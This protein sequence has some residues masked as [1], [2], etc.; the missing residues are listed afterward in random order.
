MNKPVVLAVIDGLGL[1]N[2]EQ[3]NAFAQA[4]TPV[5]DQLLSEY[6]NSVLGAASESVGLPQG[7]IGNSEVGH[8]NI[9]AGEVV[10]TGLSL[11]N[12]SIQQD[13]FKENK[14]LLES[15]EHAKKNNSTLHL[16][17]M[18]SP[19]GVHSLEDHL[20]E[21]IKLLKSKNV[22][23]VTIHAFTDGRDVKPR[24]V[25]S[26]LVKLLDIIKGTNYKLGSIGG[27]LYGMDRDANF[28]KTEIA[29]SSIMGKA[30]RQFTD[31]IEYIENQY[32]VEDH[33]D[34]FI[35]VAINSDDEVKFLSNDDAIIFFNFRPDRSRQLAHLFVGSKLYEY[36]SSKKL[37]NIQ[38]TTMMRYEGIQKATVAFD[39]WEVKNPIGK[40]LSD[41][42]MTQ[43]RVAETQKYAHVT[44]FMDGGEDVEYKGEERILVDSVKVDNFA[45]AP[46]MSAKEITDQLIGNISKYDV[47]I[48]NYANPDMVGHTGNLSAAIL[49][50]E[51][52]DKQIGRLKKYIEEIGGTLF[53]T[54]DHGNAE[55]TED[56]NGSAATK[57]TTSD[58]FLISTDKSLKLSNGVLANV[59]PTIL[60]YMG[61]DKP[62][63]MTHDS[64]I[65]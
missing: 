30:D 48:M 34:E 38:L 9:G 3:G 42:N 63:S 32:N 53:I 60:D 19:G 27:R 46:E 61:I 28:D 14:A 18:L 55:I 35:D 21:I 13:L 52:L 40:V 2:V 22:T 29:Y 58:V 62:E 56:E 47:T 26:S 43:L 17:G 6:P 37:N 23:D 54:A 7:Q 51:F 12:Q 4:N 8:L 24:S 31:V 1:R 41:N 36:N 45:D 64:L 25:K 5:L 65:K 15:I 49:A 39:S 33:N 44:F 57:H 16:V 20:W 11:V 10:Y 59:T 50:V